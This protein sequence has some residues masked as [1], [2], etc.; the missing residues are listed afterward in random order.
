MHIPVLLI[1][2]GAGGFC[3]MGQPSFRKGSG[4]DDELGMMPCSDACLRSGV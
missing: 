4:C 3:V 1:R 2:V